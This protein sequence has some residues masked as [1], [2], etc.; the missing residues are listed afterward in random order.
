MDREGWSEG[1]EYS[2]QG[3]LRLDDQNLDEKKELYK[4]IEVMALI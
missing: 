4:R 2:R 1:H 3:G